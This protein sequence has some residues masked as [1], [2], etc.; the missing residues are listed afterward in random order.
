MPVLNGVSLFDCKIA[1]T[2]IRAAWPS[3]IYQYVVRIS[4]KQR[5]TERDV[6]KV[7][8]TLDISRKRNERMLTE[9]MDVLH[10]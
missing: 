9:A 4:I 8:A 5:Y 2:R 3:S 6:S 1:E 10:P 7:V